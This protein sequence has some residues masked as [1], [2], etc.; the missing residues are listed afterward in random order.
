MNAWSASSGRVAR[1][2]RSRIAAA[3]AAARSSAPPKTSVSLPPGKCLNN[4]VTAVSAASAT[5]ATV[6]LS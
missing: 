1:P 2:A 4:V 5:S 6:T 3:I